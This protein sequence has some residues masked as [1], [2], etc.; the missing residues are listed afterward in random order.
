MSFEKLERRVKAYI[1]TPGTM[2]TTASPVSFS[3]LP[4]VE[5]VVEDSP[6]VPES[7]VNGADIL[8]SAG[9]V[10]KKEKI[11][12]AAVVYAIPEL[13]SLGRVFRTSSPVPLTENETEYVVTC[14]KH[15]L[16]DHVVLQFTVQNT[17]DDQRL[18]DVTVAVEGGDCLFEATGEIP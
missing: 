6:V 4:I 1:S 5:D 2:A 16:P 3:A 7:A 18:D 13:A 14:I 11:D 9:V 12:P 15:I 10:P 8:P 17:I